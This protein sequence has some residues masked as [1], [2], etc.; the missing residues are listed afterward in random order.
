MYEYL[1]NRVYKVEKKNLA[2]V[3]MS[4]SMF[5]YARLHLTQGFLND[6]EF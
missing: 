4:C 1:W 3:L 2:D 5:S 6:F